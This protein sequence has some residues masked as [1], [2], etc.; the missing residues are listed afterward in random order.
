M[1]LTL[2]QVGEK[3]SKAGSRVRGFAGSRVRGFAGSRVRGFAGSRVRGTGYVAP[4][5]MPLFSFR[6]FHKKNVFTAPERAI[7][8]LF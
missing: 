3:E 2:K 7:N 8:T 5:R 6:L 4:S 1:G